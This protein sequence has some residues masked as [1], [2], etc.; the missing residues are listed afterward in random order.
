MYIPK[1]LKA[2]SQGDIRTPILEAAL[3][4]VAERSK[5]PKCLLVDEW[6]K[7]NICMMEYYPALKRKESLTHVTTWRELEDIILSD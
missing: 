7:Q 5:Q 6:I 2:G 1:E 3:L 4:I